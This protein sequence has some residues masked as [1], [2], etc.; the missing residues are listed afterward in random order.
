MD[1][2]P[3]L[4]LDDSSMNLMKEKKKRCAEC[5]KKLG[6]M[7]FTC[8][9]GGDFCGAHRNNMDHACTYDFQ[10]SSKQALSTMLVKVVHQKVELI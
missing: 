2:K 5:H 4:I 6:L 1:P 7:I 10:E 9:C 8:K 3:T